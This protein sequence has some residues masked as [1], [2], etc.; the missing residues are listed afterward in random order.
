MTLKRQSSP[1]RKLMTAARIAAAHL[2]PGLPPV[3]F[4][5]DPQRTPDPARIARLLPEGWGIIHRHFGAADAEVVAAQLATISRQ[6]HLRLLIAADPQLVL[7]VGADGVHWPHAR[8]AQSRQWKD[9]MG[10]MTASAHSPAE[11]RAI[12]GFPIDAAL[13]SAIFPSASP[14][15]GKPLGAPAFRRLAHTAPCPVYALGG[16]NAGNAAS[17]AP[18]AGLAAVDGLMH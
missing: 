4:L 15:A 5:T 14:S 6:R 13:V 18:F 17:V 12:A 9:R 11:L 8:L 1:K 3:F 7:Q 2:P 16:V 10:L